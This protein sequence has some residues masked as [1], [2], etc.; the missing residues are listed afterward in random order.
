MTI[1]DM[2]QS[3]ARFLVA[4][5]SLNCITPAPRDRF[6][7][8]GLYYKLSESRVHW[9]SRALAQ[10]RRHYAPLS[11]G[12]PR[13]GVGQYVLFGLALEEVVGRLHGVEGSG[14]P[15]FVH[16]RGGV[17][18]YADRANFAVFEQAR[19]RFCGLLN[20]HERI[21]PM[22]LVQINIVGAQASQ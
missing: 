19:E 11:A 15:E 12:L 8:L 6:R 17:I 18:G 7:F 14:L 16:L 4:G 2:V 1:A 10:A 20:R 9:R 5:D 21:R 3:K 22:H 13:G